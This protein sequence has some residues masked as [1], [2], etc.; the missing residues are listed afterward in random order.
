MSGRKTEAHLAA[1]EAHL[2]YTFKGRALLAEALTHASA[3]A[4][5]AKPPRS[6]ER[7]EFLG[8]RVLGL[9]VAERLCAQFPDEG[10]SGLAPRLNA[11]VNRAACARA[12]RS[13]GLG[14]ALK[15]SPSEADQGGREKE[16]ILADA[17]EAVIAA[18]YMDGGFDAAR[19]FV[20]RF[21]AEA[22][23]AVQRLPRDAKTVLQEWAAAKKRT[24][25]YELME[26]TGPEHAP[27]FVVEAHVEG[28]APA[29]GEGRS[30]REAERAAAVAFLAEA[31]V[32]G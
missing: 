10:E 24:L 21:W 9:I 20:L 3:L 17:C 22:F 15:L 11:L 2:D 23:E 8:D 4:G 14:A 12:A 5:K 28:F 18:L 30:K 1:L 27:R 25:T 13:A 32:D 19:N 6:Y 29:R 7:L 16:Q 26:R 31:G